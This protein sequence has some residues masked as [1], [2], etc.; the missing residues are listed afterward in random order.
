MR[1]TTDSVQLTEL[2]EYRAAGRAAKG[3]PE[4]L[5][6]RDLVLEKECLERRQMVMGCLHNE[7]ISPSTRQDQGQCSHKP[8]LGLTP[9]T[10]HHNWHFSIQD[11][12]HNEPISY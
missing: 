6:R 8:G 7:N 9:T 12:N 5:N 10:R 2:S 11:H 4:L 1:I 3:R